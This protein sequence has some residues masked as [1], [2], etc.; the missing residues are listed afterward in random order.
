MLIYF[1]GLVLSLTVSI[2]SHLIIKVNRFFTFFWTFLD[3]FLPEQKPNVLCDIKIYSQLLSLSACPPNKTHTGHFSVKQ[4]RPHSL[5]LPTCPPNKHKKRPFRVFFR[6]SGFL[7]YT[8]RNTFSPPRS[9]Y[10]TRPTT[11]PRPP[12]Q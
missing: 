3:F 10:R 5:I 7:G 12:R 11:R 1:R 4:A 9:R 8:F 2:L 6:F